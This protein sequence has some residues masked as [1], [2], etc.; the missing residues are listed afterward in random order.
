MSE[1]GILFSDFAPEPGFSFP[2]GMGYLRPW[3]PTEGELL[4]TLPA[5]GHGASPG[6][7]CAWCSVWSMEMFIS[8]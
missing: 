1:A 2:W 3:H 8:V 6:H 7:E 4:A 5:S